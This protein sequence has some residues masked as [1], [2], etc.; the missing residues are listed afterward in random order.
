MQDTPYDI[1]TVFNFQSDHSEVHYSSS[2]TDSSS[3]YK[4]PQI[5]KDQLKVIIDLC[6]WMAPNFKMADGTSIGTLPIRRRF[7]LY[8]ASPPRHSKGRSDTYF[9]SVVIFTLKPGLF[10]ETAPE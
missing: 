9:H 3:I 7:G 1:G 8:V 6:I 2:D 10:S 4:S 5:E